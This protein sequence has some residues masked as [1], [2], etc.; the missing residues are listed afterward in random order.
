MTHNCSQTFPPRWSTSMYFSAS[1][2]INAVLTEGGVVETHLSY[3]CQDTL[4]PI[5]PLN[6]PFLVKLDLLAISSFL[7]L[8][9]PLEVLLHIPPF[10][11]TT[12][13][14]SK[15]GHLD[16][17]LAVENQKGKLKSKL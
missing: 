11:G 1:R 2:T 12:S 16:Y 17:P 10:H 14:D 4:L 15:A 7:G 8:F 3:S 6:K 9:W 13:N 5:S